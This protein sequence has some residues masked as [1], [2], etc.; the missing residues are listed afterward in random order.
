M[1]HAGNFTSMCV[2]ITILMYMHITFTDSTHVHW[3]CIEHYAHTVTTELLM[4]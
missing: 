2:L 4:N 3:T 1:F